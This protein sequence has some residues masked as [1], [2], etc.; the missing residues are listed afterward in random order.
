MPEIE[1]VRSLAA[2]PRYDRV[3]E[4]NIYTFTIEY[5]A[6]VVT[7]EIDAFMHGDIESICI[8]FWSH[9]LC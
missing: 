4:D 3:R 6:I 7:A 1:Y 5:D 2:Q 8:E 9:V